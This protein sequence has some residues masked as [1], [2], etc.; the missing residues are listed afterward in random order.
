MEFSFWLQICE[1][2]IEKPSRSRLPNPVMLCIGLL[3]E[4]LAPRIMLNSPPKSH[5]RCR[6][7]L[8]V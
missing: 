3:V 8:H 2:C 4:A 1:T 7:T 6:G 5:P